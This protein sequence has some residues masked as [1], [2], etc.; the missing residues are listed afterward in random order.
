ML[1]AMSD[2]DDENAPAVGLPVVAND[3]DGP[4]S[5]DDYIPSAEGPGDAPARRLLRRTR[6]VA[7]QSSGVHWSLAFARSTDGEGT[8]QMALNSFPPPKLAPLN[9]L[10]LP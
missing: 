6:P 10:P 4:C 1:Q 7:A 9:P 5:D 2:S 8:Q 3:G